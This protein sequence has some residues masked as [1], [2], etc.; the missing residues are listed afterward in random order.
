M[1]KKALNIS[2][3]G[4]FDGKTGGRKSHDKIPLKL[5]IAEMRDVKYIF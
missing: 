3:P 2:V 4:S 5:V 1:F